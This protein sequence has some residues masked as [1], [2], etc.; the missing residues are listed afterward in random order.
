[1]KRSIGVR[2]AFIVALTCIGLFAVH[3]WYQGGTRLGAGG[4]GLGIHPVPVGRPVSFGVGLTTR[5][6]PSVFVE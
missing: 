6:G 4:A 2:A 1:M 3:V 5:G